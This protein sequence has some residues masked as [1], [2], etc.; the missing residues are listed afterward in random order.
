M[1]SQIATWTDLLREIFTDEMRDRWGWGK[2]L[3]PAPGATTAKVTGRE[4]ASINTGGLDI[5]YFCGRITVN[6]DDQEVSCHA[7]DQ[8]TPADEY[9]TLSPDRHW[10]MRAQQCEW[11]L[12]PTPAEQ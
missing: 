10:W 12:R 7:F 2:K 6:F 8:K 1:P 3:R 9:W 4:S 5:P 11:P